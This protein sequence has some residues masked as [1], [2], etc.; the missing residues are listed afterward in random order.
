MT[1]TK[2][3]LFNSKV[4]QLVEVI[5]PSIEKDFIN[6]SKIITQDKFL[7]LLNFS[8]KNIV[9]LLDFTNVT[10]YEIWY[11]D[12]DS[13]FYNIGFSLVSGKGSFRIQT[14]AKYLLLW[15]RESLYYKEFGYFQCEGIRVGE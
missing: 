14:P 3:E 11:F 5:V 12:D 8:D 9:T 1:T 4:S 7:Y 10:P 13:K 2:I 15:N 6:L